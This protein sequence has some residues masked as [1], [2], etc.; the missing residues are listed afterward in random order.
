MEVKTEVIAKTL[1]SFIRSKK[2]KKK[3]SSFFLFQ[4]VV[5]IKQMC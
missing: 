2:L 5:K 4:N 1:K 3:D